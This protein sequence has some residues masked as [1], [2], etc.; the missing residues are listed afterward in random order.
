MSGQINH[1]GP[2]IDGSSNE[3]S[4]EHISYKAPKHLIFNEIKWALCPYHTL[5]RGLRLAF[6]MLLS[7]LDSVLGHSVLLVYQ[8]WACV[9]HQLDVRSNTHVHNQ[10]T[11]SASKSMTNTWACVTLDNNF[12]CKLCM[13][14]RSRSQAAVKVWAGH[15]PCSQ[16]TLVMIFVGS[17]WL[18]NHDLISIVYWE[19][20][21]DH[22]MCIIA[23]WISPA[24]GIKHFVKW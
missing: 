11:H 4:I 2:L 16:T 18:T 12:R 20:L 19:S 13:L 3:P 9:T 8:L 24:C 10:Q 7:Y 21:R 5:T 14:T 23:V 1:R 6:V 17:R 22:Q 15:Q